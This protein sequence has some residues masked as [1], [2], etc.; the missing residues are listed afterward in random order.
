MSWNS[1]TVEDGTVENRNSGNPEFRFSTVPSSTI[2]T[3]LSALDVRKSVGPDG[4]SARFLKE[5]AL[6][7][8]EPLSK[9][10]INRSLQSG[11]F[12]DEWKRCNVTPVHKGGAAD[13]P[14]NFR[15]ISVV[16]VVAKV[17]EK[18]VAAQLSAHL[19]EHKLLNSHQCAYHRKKSTEQLLMVA[20]DSVAQ[21]I[22]HNMSV[23]VAFLD[24]RKVFDLLD[25][26]ILL[27]R[28]NLLGVCK[29]GLSVISQIVISELNT[30]TVIHS[31]VW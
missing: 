15:P 3:L 23:C 2:F 25:H 26:H 22:D 19:E 16:P 24:L 13:D 21:A 8:A 14:S 5:V 11:V 20:V 12:P 1:G 27:D 29:S 17:L 9:L 4:I 6:V 7:V 10:F 30:R 31:G 18:I 28:L